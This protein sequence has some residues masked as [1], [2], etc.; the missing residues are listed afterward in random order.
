MG[1]AWE[2]F[3]TTVLRL[4]ALLEAI[5]LQRESAFAHLRINLH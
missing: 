2:S 4:T 1:L 3:N 5:K